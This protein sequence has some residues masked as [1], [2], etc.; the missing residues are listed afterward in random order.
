MQCKMVG[1]LQSR[2]GNLRG[3]EATMSLKVQKPSP[4]IETIGAKMP[5][6][7]RDRKCTSI[8]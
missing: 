3:L 5:L 1:V 4:E 7:K 2:V 8:A 6:G